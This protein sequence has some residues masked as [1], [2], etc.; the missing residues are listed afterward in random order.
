MVR[1]WI[2]GAGPFNFVIDTGAGATLVSPRVADAARVTRASDRPISIFGLSGVRSVGYRASVNSIAIGSSGNLLPAK[3]KTVISNLPHELDGILDPTEALWPFGY[4]IDIP[5]RELSVFD[6]HINPLQR[7]RIPEDG[8]VVSWVRDGESRRPFVMLGNGD[9]AL[10]DTGSGFGLAI[11]DRNA[12]SQMPSHVARDVNGGQISSRRVITSTI[13]IG[14]M[15]LQR[16]PTDLV[17][18]AD[19]GAPVLLG[20][21]ALRPFRLSFDPVNRLIEIAPGQ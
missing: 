8:T 18:G 9:R 13:S 21:T 16:I 10:I 12:G 15:T 2:N 17:S 3:G 1:T 4:T 5:R 19:S 20:L 6:P 11:R 7:D 14:L